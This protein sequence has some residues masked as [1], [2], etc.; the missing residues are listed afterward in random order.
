MKIG[1]E[2]F[3][4]ESGWQAAYGDSSEWYDSCK[5]GQVISFDDEIVCVI[6]WRNEERIGFWKKSEIFLSEED[7]RK[8][9]RKKE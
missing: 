3:K 2:V 9:K 6:Y 7:W 5:R 1:D 4:D 8:G